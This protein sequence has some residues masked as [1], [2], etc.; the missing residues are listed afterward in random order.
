MNPREKG[1]LLGAFRGAEEETVSG[2][3]KVAV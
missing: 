2:S 3:E 1:R